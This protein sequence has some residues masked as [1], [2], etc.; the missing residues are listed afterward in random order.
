[1]MHL[2]ERVLAALHY[3]TTD[4]LPYTL[5]IEEEVVLRL[6]AH[7]GGAAWRE[8]LQQHL[9]LISVPALGVRT[10]VPERYTDPFGT[11]WRT[12]RRPYHLE[13]PALT[14]PDLSGFV[15]PEI[16]ALWDA[17]IIAQQIAAAQAEGKFIVATTG[18]GIFERSWALR[19]FEN[20]M[21][22]MLLEP[23][24]Y[25]ALLDGILRIHLEIVARFLELPVDGILLSDDWGDQRGVIMGPRL[26]RKFIKPRAAQFNAAVHAGGK[27]T[28]Q[29]CC[30]SVFDIIPEMIENGLD[31][32]ESLQ[33]EAMDVYEIKRRYGQ[34]LRLWGGLGTQHLLP[35]GAPEEIHA[36][37]AR[38][39]NELGRGGGYILS[40][41]KAL[42]PEV[43]TEN[44]VAVVEAFLDA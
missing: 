36:E 41:A 21:T 13:I 35:F 7:Y 8:R 38:L 27:W 5:P 6:D 9:A 23:K 14:E 30:G 33:P 1:M 22:D 28:F 11:T 3:E 43:P 17:D 40:P 37:V 31:V 2:R 44:A 39:R 34:Q 10:D 4:V 19:G 26:W 18:F 16:D 25:E 24:F 15:W 29:H 42:M 20:A 32:L 12:D